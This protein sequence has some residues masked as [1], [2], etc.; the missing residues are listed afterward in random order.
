MENV[1][2]QII[3]V[4]AAVICDET[5]R[6]LIAKRKKNLSQ[7]LKWEF[8]GGKLKIGE[9]PGNCLKREI[10]EELGIDIN[11]KEI[12]FA[13]NHQYSQKHILLLAYLAEFKSGNFL[14]A[15]HEEVQWIQVHQLRDFEL[16]PADIPIADK[17]I[18]QHKN[19][20]SGA[21]E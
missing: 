13:V 12:Y 18:R 8:P 21:D 7:G 19:L 3:P 17:L 6:I 10:R 20:R 9:S 4:L 2:K 1:K 14:L 15:D 5:G 11:V 16:S